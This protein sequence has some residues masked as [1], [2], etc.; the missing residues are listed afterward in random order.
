MDVSN[1]NVSNTVDLES[2][3]ETVK[4][5]FD[6]LVKK[7]D[8]LNTRLVQL[9]TKLESTKESISNIE[10]MWKDQYGLNSYEE[11]IAEEKRLS[12]EIEQTLN[13]CEAYLSKVG[14]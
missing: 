12:E 6:R 4:E 3:S 5:R 11:V 10:T 1:N 13:K 7:R 8:E 9:S 2:H 14:V